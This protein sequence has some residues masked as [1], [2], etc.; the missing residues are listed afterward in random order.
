MNCSLCQTRKVSEASARE[1]ER[2]GYRLICSY[3]LAEHYRWQRFDGELMGLLAAKRT[4]GVTVG[5]STDCANEAVENYSNN[6]SMLE[7]N[8]SDTT[9]DCVYPFSMKEAA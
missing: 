1:C 8:I 3:C 5:F 6:Y 9:R 2:K 7:T 4:Q